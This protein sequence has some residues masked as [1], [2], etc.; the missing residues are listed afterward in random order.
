[1]KGKKNESGSV[2]RRRLR[3]TDEV[4]ARGMNASAVIEKIV[5]KILKVNIPH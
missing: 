1:M 4:V 5:K 2:V 3:S